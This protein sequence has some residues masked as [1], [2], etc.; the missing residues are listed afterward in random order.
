M[1]SVLKRIDS[2]SRLAYK[3]HRAGDQLN[4]WQLMDV[5]VM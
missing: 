2:S 4:T 1:K 3:I 5:T